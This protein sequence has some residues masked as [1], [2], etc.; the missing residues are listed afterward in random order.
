MNTKINGLINA[1]KTTSQLRNPDLKKDA[2]IGTL[3]SGKDDSGVWSEKELP[4]FKKWSGSKKYGIISL[5]DK[6]AKKT[7]LP[8]QLR[9]DEFHGSPEL[10]QLNWKY[11]HEM[12]ELE[13]TVLGKR[14]PVL[15]IFENGDG[16]GI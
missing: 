2:V 10:E 4:R 6:K 5:D 15:D 16:S 11:Y 9:K 3:L 1:S 12:R 8:F 13:I 7:T 14:V